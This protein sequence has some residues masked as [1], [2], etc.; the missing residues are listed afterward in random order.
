MQPKSIDL[1]GWSVAI[2]QFLT[3]GDKQELERIQSKGRRS[4]KFGR[5]ASL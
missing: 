5:F 1:P 4:S 2:F 3:S